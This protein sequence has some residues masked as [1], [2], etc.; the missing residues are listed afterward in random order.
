MYIS[1]DKYLNG[2]GKRKEPPVQERCRTVGMSP[3]K[4][5]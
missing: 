5:H 4:D 2:Q 3:E 1:T